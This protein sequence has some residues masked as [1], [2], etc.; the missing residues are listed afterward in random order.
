[1]KN[2]KVTYMFEGET[3]KVT[4]SESQFLNFEK[5][6]I[7]GSS[8]EFLLEIEEIKEVLSKC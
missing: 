8:E 3:L 5:G 7:D 4:M 1:M 2:Y 6:L